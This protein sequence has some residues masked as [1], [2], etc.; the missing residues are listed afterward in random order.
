MKIPRICHKMWADFF[1]YFWCP[2]PV[3]GEYWGG[4]EYSFEKSGTLYYA[5]DRGTITCKNC[6]EE[7]NRINK[8]N[9]YTLSRGTIRSK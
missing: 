8:E 9:G 5:P 7:A 2:C 4:H 1:G 6:K 3:C